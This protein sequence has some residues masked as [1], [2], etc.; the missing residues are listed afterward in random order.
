MAYNP[1]TGHGY[2]GTSLDLLVREL[3]HRISNLFTVIQCL[4]DQTEST[5]AD[6]YRAALSERIAALSDA[7]A[8]I[9]CVEERPVS[10]A[11]LLT[12]TLKPY[13]AIRENRIFVA[14][15]HVELDRKLALSPHMVFHELATNANKHGALALPSGRVEVLWN[16]PFEGDQRLAV[17]WSESGGPAVRNPKHEG[18]GLRLIEAASSDAMIE[19]NFDPGGLVCRILIRTDQFE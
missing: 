9:E 14:G 15:P 7:Y 13:S 16:F 4:V 19:M 2:A 5:T 12:H 3:Q 8:I 11:K 17:Q 6:G 18:F 1:N 10:L